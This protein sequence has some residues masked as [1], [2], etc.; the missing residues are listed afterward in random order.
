MRQVSQLCWHRG[1]RQVVVAAQTL[2]VVAPL[3]SHCDSFAKN[4]AASFKKSRSFFT[5]ASSRLSVAISSSR[6][7]PEPRNAWIPEAWSSRLQRPSIFGLMP[8]SC[9]IWLWVTFG[10]LASSTAS[11]LNSSEYFRRF[12]MTHLLGPL[13]AFLAVSAK[14]G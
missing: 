7:L 14:S 10:S 13:S 12:E 4:A 1:V 11:R 8:N 2:A 6:G 3:V 5:R 9:A